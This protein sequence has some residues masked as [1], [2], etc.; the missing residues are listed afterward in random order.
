[1][2]VAHLKGDGAIPSLIAALLYDV[3]PLYFLRNVCRQV[4][5][6]KKKRF[7]WNKAL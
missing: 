7:V 6:M 4:K 5:W 2:K 1:M 3:K